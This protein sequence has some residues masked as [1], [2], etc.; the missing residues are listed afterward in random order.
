MNDIET[1]DKEHPVGGDDLEAFKISRRAQQAK[2]QR[3]TSPYTLSYRQQVE[4]SL[5][6]AR[7]P[8]RSQ[9][10]V[11]ICLWRGFRRLAADPSLMLTQIIGNSIFA[12]ILSSIFYNLQPNTDSFYRRGALLFFAVSFTLSFSVNDILKDMT[13]TDSL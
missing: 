12:L 8:N 7:N 3:V 6:P 9:Y 2:S 13:C 10:L 11:Q 5:G 4:V 1:F